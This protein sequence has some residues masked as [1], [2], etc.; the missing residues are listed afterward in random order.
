VV[1]A[2]IAILAAMLL[3][4]LSAAKQKAKRVNCASN[5]HQLS[6]ANACYMDDFLQ[7]FITLSDGDPTDADGGSVETYHRWA[8]KEGAGGGGVFAPWEESNRPL[9]PYVAASSNVT[10]NNTAGIYRVFCCP[11][12]N[13]W[14]A[15]RGSPD[16]D[17]AFSDIGISYRYNSSAQNNDGTL[18]LWNKK[19]SDVV[20]PAKVLLAYEQPFDIYSFNWLGAWPMPLTY[21][22]WHNKKVNGW[23]NMV[24]VDGHVVYLLDSYRNPDFQHGPGWTSVYNDPTF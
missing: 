17:S 20:R 1:I 16:M 19:L 10:S 21:C 7:K 8:G 15:G 12:D 2:I 13:G 6:I 5:L 4:A 22:Y 3:P 23:A 14:G 18:G 24:I 9:N 11:S